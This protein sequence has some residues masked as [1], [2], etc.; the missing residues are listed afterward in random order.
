M[1]KPV[2]QMIIGTYQQ[3]F[4]ELT[5]AVL[6]SMRGIKSNDNNRMRAGLGDKQI[7][8]TVVKNNLAKQAITGTELEPAASLLEEQTAFVYPVD[9]EVSVVSVARELLDWARQIKQLE[10]RGAVMDGMTFGPDEIK[11][12]SDFPTREE[13]QAQVIQIILSP[14]QNL[15]GSVLGPGRKVASLVKAVEEKL[16]KGEEIRKAG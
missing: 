8:I 16:E 11:K 13:A 5:G 12:L 14:A 1:S 15:V 9:D 3:R 10:F 6:V 4:S 7:R 2:K